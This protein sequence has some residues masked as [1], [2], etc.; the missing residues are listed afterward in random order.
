MRRQLTLNPFFSGEKTG[1]R[2]LCDLPEPRNDRAQTG[3]FVRPRTKVYSWRSI[4]SMSLI[5][6]YTSV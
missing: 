1:L 2:R 6:R 3:A 4:C 5:R